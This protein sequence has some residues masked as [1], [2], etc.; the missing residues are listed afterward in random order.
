[1]FS[2]SVWTIHRRLLSSFFSFFFLSQSLST[3]AHFNGNIL[4]AF[5]SYSSQ[6]NKKKKEEEESAYYTTDASHSYSSTV[7]CQKHFILQYLIFKCQS[8]R[9]VFFCRWFSVVVDDNDAG[10]R[11]IY[12]LCHRNREFCHFSFLCEIPWYIF[13]ND[14]L[15]S[16]NEKNKNKIQI[17]CGLR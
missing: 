1:M 4:S 9:L 11:W 3:V 10:A 8:V 16:Q 14:S 6:K 15:H 7:L 5:A 2:H 17:C 12:N 13:I